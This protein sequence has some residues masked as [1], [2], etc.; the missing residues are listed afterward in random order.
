MSS[1]TIYSNTKWTSC[2]Q[3]SYPCTWPQL[4]KASLHKIPIKQRARWPPPPDNPQSFQTS[5]RKQEES[6]GNSPWDAVPVIPSPHSTKLLF[7]VQVSASSSFFL[8]STLHHPQLPYTDYHSGLN[9]GNLVSRGRERTQ[10]LTCMWRFRGASW[11]HVEWH[12]HAFTRLTPALFLYCCA[13][14]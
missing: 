2:W 8:C 13:L 5:W 10:W 14:K 1:A 9:E 7:A 11:C 12:T 3:S 4:A 6:A